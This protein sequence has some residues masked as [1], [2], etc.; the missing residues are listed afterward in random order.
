MDRQSTM[1]SL[2]AR[3]ALDLPFVVFSVSGLRGDLPSLAAYMQTLLLKRRSPLVFLTSLKITPCSSGVVM[4]R[5]GTRSFSLHA[6]GAS[7]C[8]IIAFSRGRKETT[9][10]I[11]G[12]NLTDQWKNCLRR[13]LNSMR[14]SAGIW[15][16]ERKSSHGV[17][18]CSELSPTH[19]LAMN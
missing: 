10:I 3:M 1:I 5:S 11:A 6:E 13:I 15:P 19:K 7:C 8:H 16:L 17:Y 18:G 12:G 14:K 9:W 4:G 2:S